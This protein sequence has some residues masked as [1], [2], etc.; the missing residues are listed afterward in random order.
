MGYHKALHLQGGRAEEAAHGCLEVLLADAVSC[1]QLPEG[2][3]ELQASGSATEMYSRHSYRRTLGNILLD[4]PLPHE[5]GNPG[6]PYCGL[7]DVKRTFIGRSQCS[8]SEVE[9]DQICTLSVVSFCLL[10][11]WQRHKKP[12]SYHTSNQLIA[13]GRETMGSR[14]LPAFLHFLSCL[15]F[16][17]L[18]WF[19]SGIRKTKRKRKL[20]E[21]HQ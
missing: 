10:F 9:P 8:A 20:R 1:K 3:N 16:L 17:S 19:W 14:G 11:F 5:A 2:R 13:V 15:D 12:F 18:L 4:P 7:L 6:L 21:T